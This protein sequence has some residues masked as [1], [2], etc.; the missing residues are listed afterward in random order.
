V[1]IRLL[2]GDVCDRAGSFLKFEKNRSS[3]EVRFHL[4]TAV[5]GFG[6]KTVTAL[7]VLIYSEL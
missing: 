6:F 7:P 3:V 1:I 4:K 5:F 2:F